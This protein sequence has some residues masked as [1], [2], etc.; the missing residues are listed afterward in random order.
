MLVWKRTWLPDSET[1]VR[2]QMRS[3]RSWRAIGV[4]LERAGSG[5][6]HD[7]SDRI[8]HER[9]GSRRK[10][11]LMLRHLGVSR[12]LDALV[13][14]LAPTLIHA[15]FL[16]DA[17]DIARFAR[18]RGLPL[19]VTGHG[20]D[21]TSWPLVMGAPRALRPVARLR[22]SRQARAV[23]RQARAVIG[24]SRFIADRLVRLGS[25]PERTV[26]RAIGI[27][28]TAPPPPADGRKGVVFVGRLVEK[29]GVAD[30]LD[31]MAGLPPAVRD[32]PVTIVGDG[33]LRGSLSARAERLGLR[34]VTFAGMQP[35]AAVAELLRGA[36]VFCAPSR[37]AWNGD[38]E[39]FGMVFLEAALAS[40]PVVATRHGGIPEAVEDG[41]TGLL[42]PEGDVDALRR[43]L[44]SILLDPERAE[45]MGQAGRERVL[46]RFDVR[47][48]TTELERVYDLAAGR[49][50]WPTA[51]RGA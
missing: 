33:H 28:V 7:P 40:A 16:I 6:L 49:S 8:L 25:A 15:H 43:A 14:E 24:V 1:F 45:R 10:H 22:R 4:G 19:V 2:N 51:G 47:E 36:T 12:S 38:S 32:V 44:E 20:Y 34:S 29:K 9:S 31:A 48:R 18:R 46:A 27:P 39:G 41:V 23:F 50:V 3:L 37:T 30:L 26:V 17:T 35:P 42:V 13:D 21:V 11:A 5:T